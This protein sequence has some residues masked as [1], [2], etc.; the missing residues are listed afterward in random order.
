MGGTCGIHGGNEK[1]IQGCGG[2]DHVE[3][4]GEGVI[5]ERFR[6]E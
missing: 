5:L 6:K 1:C 3:G 4:V 2:E